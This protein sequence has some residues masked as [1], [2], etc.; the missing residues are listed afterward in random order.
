M[1]GKGKYF[2]LRE[3]RPDLCGYLVDQPFCLTLI[4][5][6]IHLVQEEVHL[7]ERSRLTNSFQRQEV[8]L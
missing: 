2:S 4:M 8:L 3:I 5:N 6:R 7:F 1:G